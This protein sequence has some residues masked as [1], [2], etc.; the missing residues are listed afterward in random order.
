MSIENE[1]DLSGSSENIS[2]SEKI[3]SKEELGEKNIGGALLASGS[4]EVATEPRTPIPPE[5]PPATGA[6]EKRSM[7]QMVF[8]IRSGWDAFWLV[9]AVLTIVGS[10]VLAKWDLGLSQ[11][12]AAPMNALLLGL[13]LASWFAAMCSQTSTRAWAAGFAIAGVI[14]WALDV[15]HGAGGDLSALTDVFCRGKWC[16]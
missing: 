4:S 6:K 5:V 7:F 3:I 16:R 11:D 14:I 1:T 2:D 8:G 9:L 12:P 10:I 13:L 15:V